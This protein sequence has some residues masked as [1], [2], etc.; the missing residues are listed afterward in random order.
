MVDV[1]WNKWYQT[2]DGGWEKKPIQAKS[3]FACVEINV[4][5]EGEESNRYCNP[6]RT[7]SSACKEN[8]RRIKLSKAE[9]YWKELQHGTDSWGLYRFTCLDEYIKRR[10]YEPLLKK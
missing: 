4:E 9:Q 5:G 8:D 2:S 7:T 10:A 1:G 3:T 6:Q